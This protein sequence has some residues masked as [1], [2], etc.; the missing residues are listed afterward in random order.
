MTESASTEP[1]TYDDLPRQTSIVERTITVLLMVC[2]AAL[3]PIASFFGLFFGMA[4][5]GCVGDNPCDSNQLGLGVALAA[6]SPTVVFLAALVWVIVRVAR[7][8]SA[9]WVPLVGLAVG[10]GLWM[11]GGLIAFSAVG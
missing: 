9:W 8:R 11:L 10:I 5:D 4:S 2:L 1:T 6:A 3:V 7:R